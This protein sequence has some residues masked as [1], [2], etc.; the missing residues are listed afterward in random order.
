MGGAGTRSV[1]TIRMPGFPRAG[2]PAT[3][4]TI[5]TP[6]GNP[7]AS[8]SPAM[9]STLHGRVRMPRVTPGAGGVAGG[10]PDRGQ[11]DR[12]QRDRAV[13]TTAA[14]AAPTASMPS[15][16]LARFR[17]HLTTAAIASLMTLAGSQLATQAPSQPAATPVPSRPAAT[18]A[19]SR[20]H[21]ARAVTPRAV[22]PAGIQADVIPAGPP[23]RG[24]PAS[25]PVPAIPAVF[26]ARA[27]PEA[28]RVR[29]ARADNQTRG[30][31]PS[32]PPLLIRAGTWA[33]RS[34]ASTPTHRR[35]PT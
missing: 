6:A 31:R 32:S 19:R 18:P 26:V 2:I 33:R 10:H 20:P 25:P 3:G 8:A 5:G 23:A 14:S 7:R 16:T 30:T 11:R 24:T 34:S 27:I 4:Q 15:A 28:P 22:T 29:V 17:R 9:S 12:G 35:I 13:V 1:L 21:L